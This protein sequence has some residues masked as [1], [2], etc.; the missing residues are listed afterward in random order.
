MSRH[1]WT[2]HTVKQKHTN[3]QAAAKVQTEWK[4]GLSWGH[5]INLRRRQM[6]NKDGKMKKSG[7]F[8]PHKNPFCLWYTV[9]GNVKKGGKNHLVELAHQLTYCGF[10]GNSNTFLGNSLDLW[11]KSHKNQ[12]YVYKY[13][14]TSPAKLGVSLKVTHC[15]TF[16]DVLA[17]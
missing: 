8:L 5:N 11:C 14:D 3:T 16:S 10:R 7:I 12:E 4:P 15:V 9:K 2:L 6:I 17:G 1:L 13:Q